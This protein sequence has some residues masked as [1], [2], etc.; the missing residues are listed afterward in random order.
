MTTTLPTTVVP[1]ATEWLVS[2]AA[3]LD[4]SLVLPGDPRWDAVRAAWQVAVDQQPAAVALV[5]SARDVVTVVRAARAAGLRVAAQSTGHN[6]GP[7]GDLSDTVLV[8]TGLLRDVTVDPVARTAR[9]EAGAEWGDVTVAAGRHGLA[10]LAGSSR[11][12]GVAGYTLGGGLSWLARSHGLAANSVVALEV[13]TAG[14]RLIRVDATHDPDL[15]WALRGGGGSFGV[16]TALEL[17]LFPI[18]EVHAGILFFPVERAAEVLQAWREWLP[19]VPETVTSVGR[20]LRFPPLPDLPPHLSGRSYVVVEAAC[21]LD[22]EEADALLAPLRALGPSLDTF[23]PTPVTELGL[24]HM[25]PDGP[26]PAH[27]DGML[28]DDL[29]EGAIA[30]FTGA[31]A[32]A[33]PALLSLELRHLG[34]A[35][36]RVDLA[37]GAVSAIDAGFALF[38]VGI[39]PTPEASAAVRGAVRSVRSAMA[40]WSTG[41]C[42]LNFAEVAR[43]GDELFGAATHD[44]LRAVKAAYDPADVIRSNHPVRPARG[45]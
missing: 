9:V 23:G 10:A 25:D 30:A 12:V 32:A 41:G 29:D 37:G 40:P 7:L 33:G 8:R 17:R 39:T 15:F 22:A 5:G 44:R 19:G 16:V 31:S 4:G 45:E 2:L 13:V 38:A 21:Q 20:I 14:G 34:G 18:R 42:Y 26:V 36:R 27:G 24:L 43:S 3:D 1:R 28:L 11:D 6:A 35:V